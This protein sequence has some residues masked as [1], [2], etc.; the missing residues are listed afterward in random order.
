M[1]L[2]SPRLECHGEYRRPFADSAGFSTDDIL[3]E[4]SSTQLAHWPAA[5][6][7]L[8]RQIGLNPIVECLD[9]C[10]GLLLEHHHQ[11]G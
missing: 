10:L 4:G 1:S 9:D 6:G 11:L 5:S 8:S 3:G 7:L 2:S